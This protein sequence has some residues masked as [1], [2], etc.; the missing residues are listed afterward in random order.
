MTSW[1]QASQRDKFRITTCV[2]CYF[3]G[4]QLLSSCFFFCSSLQRGWSGKVAME[5]PDW[6]GIQTSLLHILPIFILL[7]FILTPR[8]DGSPHTDAPF[9][10]ISCSP[11]RLSLH[12]LCCVLRFDSAAADSA[13]SA[14]S[15]PREVATGVGALKL[16]PV[17]THMG[18][19]TQVDNTNT[20]KIWAGGQSGLLTVLSPF[21]MIIKNCQML[22]K[23]YVIGQN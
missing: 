6:L 5:P 20:R 13:G 12:L 18:E 23:F 22:A 4:S 14:D 17:S 10:A 7:W 15:S 2:F 16:P 19:Q 11:P 3:Y 8:P 9:L 1:F 21:E